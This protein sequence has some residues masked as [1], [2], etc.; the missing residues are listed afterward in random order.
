MAK[1]FDPNGWIGPVIFSAKCFLQKLWTAQLTWDQPL[2]GDL[3][4]EWTLFFASLPDID[5]VALPRRFL[6][7]GKCSVALHGFCDASERGFAAVLFLRVVDSQGTATVHLVMSKTKVAPLRTRLTIPKLELSGAALV[8]RLLNHVAS[9]LKPDMDVRECFAWTDSEIVLSW[10]KLPAHTLEVFVANRISQIQNSEIPLIWRHVPGEMNPADC[11]SRGCSAPALLQQDLW[12]GPV[13]LTAPEQSWPPTAIHLVDPIPCVRIS[14]VETRPVFD[15]DFLLNRFSSLSKLIGVT[16]WTKRFIWNCR[17]PSERRSSLF[18]SPDERQEALLYWIRSVQRVHFDSVID[19]L[20][21]GRSRLKGSVA[22]LNP[23]LDDSGLIRVGGRLRNSKLPFGSRHP[24][25]LPKGGRLVELLVTDRHIR[26]S[27]PGCN[28]LLAIL[29][30]EFW[31]LSARRIIRSV[32]FRCIPCYRLKAATM[33]PQMGDLP[34]DRVSAT[35]PFAGVGTDFAGPFRVKTSRLRNARIE[36]AYLCVFV[37]LSTKAVDLEIVSSLS[38]EAFMATLSRFVSRRGLPALMRSDCGTNFKGAN[39]YLRDVVGFLESNSKDIGTA[40]SRQGIKWLFDPPSCPHWGGIFES[41][42]KV[43]KTHLRRVIGETVLT[44]EELDTVF[45]KIEAVL[46]S[47]PL[48]PLSSDP[49]DLEVLSPGHF[50]IGQPLNALPEYPFVDVGPNRLSRFEA[51]QRMT[52]TFW[53]RFSL[54]YLHLL[55]QRVKWSDKTNPPSI[56]DL[57]LVKDPNL[58]PLQWRRG[59]ILK[60]FPGA[61]GTPRFAE[62][63][64]GDSILKRAVATLSRLPIG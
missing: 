43:A 35:R 59:R 21:E 64:V 30:R 48:C 27:H 63:M 52:Q 61:D 33:Q 45:C 6:P 1:T 25:L 51:L 4:R 2:T 28:A 29:Q 46:N 44:Y 22:R 54:E 7:S 53:H 40:L 36:K 50:L 12:W 58:P 20:H 23:F 19:I 5:R 9:L 49:N 18:L 34:A 37:C 3:L 13:W 24:L 8:T 55:Q 56:G 14:A 15:E 62:V 57:V 38:T 42:V 26:S 11:A 17:H 47:R 16:G 60:L 32:L 39:N 41:V 10:L 31:I